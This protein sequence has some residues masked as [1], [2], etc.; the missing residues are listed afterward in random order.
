[1]QTSLREVSNRDTSR[2]EPRPLEAPGRKARPVVRQAMFGLFVVAAIAL[3]SCKPIRIGGYTNED[4]FRK[5]IRSI[6]VPVFARGP[7]VFRRELE[8]RLTEAVVKRIQL[9]TGWK[10]A[11]R[12]AADAELV[13]CLDLVL[14]TVLSFDSETALGR[15]K[16]VTL[17]ASFTL[18]DLRT[19]KELVKCANLRGSGAYLPGDPFREDFLHG[20]EQAINKL[21]RRIVEQLEEPW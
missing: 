21:A 4:H 17:V 13:A 10:I 7:Q 3:G 1:M 8:I 16:E 12:E 5:D 6:H 19:G 14:Q 15:E 11:K 2:W 20:S 18:R 9:D